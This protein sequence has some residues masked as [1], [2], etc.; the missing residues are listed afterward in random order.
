MLG[1]P[2][3]IRS[4]NI[5][6]LLIYLHHETGGVNAFAQLLAAPDI[7]SSIP[8]EG[9]PDSFLPQR[10]DTVIGEEYPFFKKIRAFDILFIDISCYILGSLDSNQAS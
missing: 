2:L 6:G 9:F 3:G 4:E 8:S 5:P 10:R 1:I 7:F